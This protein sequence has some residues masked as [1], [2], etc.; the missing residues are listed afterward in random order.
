[1]KGNI[2]AQIR[3]DPPTLANLGI[4]NC[5]FFIGYLD[6]VDHEMDFD[7]NLFFSFTKLPFLLVE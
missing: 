3:L 2:W 6:L 5:Y 1:M 7:I 4:L